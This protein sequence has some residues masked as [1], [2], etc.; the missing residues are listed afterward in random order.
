M[1]DPVTRATWDN[2]LV[3]SPAMAKTLLNIDLNNN[4]QADNYEVQPPK[5][6]V[7]IKVNGKTIKLPALIIPGTHKDT[8]GIAVGYGR[9]KK[10]GRTVVDN[11]GQLVGANVFPF[12]AI[13]DGSVSFDITEVDLKLTDEKYPVALT[14]TH[15]IY[16]TDQG[17]RI[18][19]MK[20]LTFAQYKKIQKKY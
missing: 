13:A 7:E 17:N 4:G 10:V 19:V 2:Y 14:Q 18:E 9:D 11:N 12:A 8:V 16:N 20:E 1:P 15:N 6:V 5:K 3:V